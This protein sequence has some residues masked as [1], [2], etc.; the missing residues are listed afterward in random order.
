MNIHFQDKKLFD[1]LNANSIVTI[2]VG[3]HLYN[4]DNEKSDTDFLTIYF[5]NNQS[6][7][8]EHH[9]LQYK[10]NGIDFNFTTIQNFIRNILTG[11]A[12]INFE[13][14]FSEELKHSKLSF[15][16]ENRYHF[17]NYHIIRSYLGL[18][19]RDFK[20]IVK[21]TNNFKEFSADDFKKVSHFF[22]GFVFSNMLIDKTFDITLNSTYLKYSLLKFNIININGNEFK[23]DYDFIKTVKNEGILID[24]NVIHFIKYTMEELENNREFLNKMMENKQFNKFMAI[25][26]MK[27]IDESVMKVCKE[28]TYRSDY[29]GGM[30]SEL[31]GGIIKY[32]DLMYEALE[33]GII[34]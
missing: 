33:N 6:F 21:Y 32:G 2:K 5:E 19:K 22:R 34:Y 3:S 8:W 15:L 10:E 4:L 12:T 17:I 25:D 18:A 13:V 29:I 14:L 28:Y 11:D 31:S 7:L 9:Q 30:E 20:M 24:E 27:T 26:M 16:Y 1:I 23:N